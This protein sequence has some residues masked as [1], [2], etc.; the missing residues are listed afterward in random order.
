MKGD[1]RIWDILL[2]GSAVR[3]KMKPVDIDAAIIFSCPTKLEEKLSTSQKVREKLGEEWQVIGMDLNDLTDENFLA[4]TGIIAEGY[5][6]KRD[7]QFGKLLGFIPTAIFTYSLENLSNND[8][9]RL[10]Y[11]LSGRK[12]GEGL[13]PKWGGKFLG[14]G[15]ILVPIEFMDEL[16]ELFESFNVRFLVK[17]ALVQ[18]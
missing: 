15:C 7:E 4:R 5:S 13:L 11:A 17:K 10:K 2:F 3:G 9:T 14:K 1:K 18:E 6:V 12:K 16:K 8:R